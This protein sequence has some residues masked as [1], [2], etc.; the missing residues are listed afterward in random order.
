MTKNFEEI[1]DSL[2]IAKSDPVVDVVK[3]EVVSERDKILT[4]KRT[5]SMLE[6]ITIQ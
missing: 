3:S 5:M 1:E 2:G 6:E 4:L